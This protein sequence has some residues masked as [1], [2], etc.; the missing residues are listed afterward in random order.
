MDLGKIKAHMTRVFP[1][2]Y[3]PKEMLPGEQE[4]SMEVFR[5][6][7]FPFWK[8]IEERDNKAEAKMTTEEVSAIK[9][10][11]EVTTTHKQDKAIHDSGHRPARIVIPP[12]FRKK[13]AASDKFSKW[14]QD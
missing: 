4:A 8:S 3:F 1:N 9:V 7:I 5:R 10:L 11:M 12:D 14:N 13:A 6:A 2:G